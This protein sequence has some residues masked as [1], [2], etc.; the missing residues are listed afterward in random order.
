MRVWVRGCPRVGVL[1]V[2]LAASAMSSQMRK[3]ARQSDALVCTRLL[4][5]PSSSPELAHHAHLLETNDAVC[6]AVLCRAGQSGSSLSA[7]VR[8]P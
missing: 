4:Q 7:E 2:S 1:S 3:G 8:A 6:C 5:L